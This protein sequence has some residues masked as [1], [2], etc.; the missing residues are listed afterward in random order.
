MTAID[1]LLPHV[2]A[3]SPTPAPRPQRIALLSFPGI[4]AFDISVIT[5]VWGSDR[6]LRGVPPFDL[7]RAAAD[8]HTPIPLRGGLSLTPDRPL[9]WLDDLTPDDLVLVP[10]IED[11]DADLPTPVLEDRKSVV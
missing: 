7:R 8:P 11:P 3:A 6:T 1:D 2:P 5:E 4:R 10:G 9:S